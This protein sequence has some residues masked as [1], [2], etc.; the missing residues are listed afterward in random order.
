MIVLRCSTNFSAKTIHYPC[1]DPIN[2]KG[3]VLIHSGTVIMTNDSCHRCTS[4]E[5]RN[6]QT[7]R[8]E[9][10]RLQHPQS[11]LGPCSTHKTKDKPSFGVQVSTR[12]SLTV[13]QITHSEAAFIHPSTS[14]SQFGAFILRR[15]YASLL[16]SG[17]PRACKCSRSS[18]TPTPSAFS[19]HER[20]P[21][22][23]GAGGHNRSRE[24]TMTGDAENER[25]H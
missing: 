6:S 10:S 11:V 2:G 4:A 17:V 23:G 5:R 7:M 12:T 1:I 25:Q 3:I 20:F 19:S 9:R 15:L 22:G 13:F 8:R 24:L 14:R 16:F 18:F 21:A